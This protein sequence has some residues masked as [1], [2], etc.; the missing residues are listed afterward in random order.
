MGVT[1][2]NDTQVIIVGGGPVGVGLAVE[3]GLRGVSCIVVERRTGMHN[4]PKGQNLT[5]RT[6]EHFY[7]WGII[8]EIRAAR[9]MPAGFP[10]SGL[11]AYGNLR[12]EYWY[13]PPMREIVN[14]YY[15]QKNDRLPQYEMEKVLRAKAGTIPG[16]ELRLGWAAE[17]VADNGDGV[18]LT[19]T[20]ESSGR[21]IEL[22]ADYL[23]GCDGA[24]S[25]VRDRIGIRRSGDDY[26]QLMVLAVF[27]SKEFHDGLSRYPERSTYRVMKPELNGYWQFFGRIDVGEGFFFHAPVPADT[28]RENYDFLGLLHDAAGFEFDAEFDHLGFWDLRVL[29]AEEYR[30]GRIF[31]AGDAAHS[32]PP[33]GGFG[34]NNGLEDIRNLGWKVAARLE[35]WGGETLLDSYGLERQPV[36]RDIGETLIGGRIRDDA[37]FFGEFN[38]EKDRAAFEEAWEKESGRAGGFIRRY[39]PSYGGSPVVVTPEGAITT[40]IGEHSFEA[41]AGHH[42][43]PRGLSTGS[44]VYDELGGGFALIALDASD[45][46]IR[47]F[48][49]A[50]GEIVLPLSIVRDT[51]ADERADYGRRFILVRP[52]HHIAWCANEI[53]D[54]ARALFRSVTGAQ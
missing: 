34:L 47:A 31:I 37:A 21:R 20:E 4:V 53:P 25:M 48:A 49:D 41:R 54:D 36:F 33:Y 15:F 39:E 50:A 26:D 30:K 8:D 7:C 35:G 6:L 13:A 32:H 44:N 40:A 28:T 16:V 45:D 27:R 38:P 5:A 52:D 22:T 43:A 42:L 12:S 3:L 1:M 18:T 2:S 23:A 11:T 9:V 14:P 29:V 10:E 51:A 19:M 24:H 17:S 46:E